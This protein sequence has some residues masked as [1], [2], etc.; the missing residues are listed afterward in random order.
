[1]EHGTS[2]RRKPALAGRRYPPERL[3]RKG[4]QPAVTNTPVLCSALRSLHSRGVFLP[5]EKSACCV[6][7]SRKAWLDV[8]PSLTVKYNK[9]VSNVDWLYSYD[10]NSISLKLERQF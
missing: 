2:T 9:V 7:L 6:L 4:L 3:I 10:K 8:V 5:A 1:M